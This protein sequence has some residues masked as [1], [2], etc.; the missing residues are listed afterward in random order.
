MRMMLVGAGAVGESILKI[1]ER[2]DPDREWLDF[3][4]ICDYDENRAR[5][6]E[7]NLA[8]LP[9]PPLAH[10]YSLGTELPLSA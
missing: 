4:L 10:L 5:E 8:S 7:E 9:I 2:R 1:L 3:V 6:V